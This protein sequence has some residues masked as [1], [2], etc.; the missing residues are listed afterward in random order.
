MGWHSKHIM[1]G[2]P[3][4]DYEAEIMGMIGAKYNDDNGKKRDKYTADRPFADLFAEKQMQILAKFIR[5]KDDERNIRL[6]VLGVL[7]L[8]YGAPMKEEVRTVVMKACDDDEWGKTN[9]ERRIYLN[10]F[11]GIVEK[12]DGK[13]PTDETIDHEKEFNVTDKDW[14][15]GRLSSKMAM[16]AL[17]YYRKHVESKKW[18]KKLDIGVSPGGYVIVM[19]VTDKFLRTVMKDEDFEWSLFEVPVV[20][21]SEDELASEQ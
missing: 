5:K 1:G 3:P 10:D 6:Q 21:L 12:Y 15:H 20:L 7:I 9:L 14:L 4:W 19:T 13:T 8:K 16:M 2:D 11:K 18:M 17:H